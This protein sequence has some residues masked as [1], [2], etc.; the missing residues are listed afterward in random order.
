MT[1]ARAIT[2]SSTKKWPVVSRLGWVRIQWAA[3]PMMSGVREAA[4]ICSPPS[5]FSTAAVA[6][7]VR[8]QSALAA[9]PA[10]RNSP[11]QP[12]THIDIPNFEMVYATCGA[13]QRSSMLSGGL[14]VRMCGSRPAA[15]LA[16][17]YGSAACVTQNVPRTLTPTIRSNRF[18]GVCAVPARKMADALL[19]TMSMPPKW[20]A[21]CFIASATRASSRA[22]TWS[23]S[24]CPPAAS[25]SAAAVWIVPSRRGC[26]SAV[27]AATTMLAPSRAAR[28]AIAL[29]MPRLAPVMKR[30]FPAS[31]GIGSGSPDGAGE[32]G[33]C[34]AD[35]G[36][37]R[38]FRGITVHGS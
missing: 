32:E 8:G 2:S 17:R 5:R 27:L 37:P 1:P 25:I 36:L 18:I 38:R 20:S 31:V 9:M 11:A 24:A 23:A 12:R 33:E 26:G 7:V 4:I 16:S 35:A 21:A 29:P 15:A 13:N 22:S 14:R 28:S 6:I 30:V 34:T 3:S 19:T 10:S